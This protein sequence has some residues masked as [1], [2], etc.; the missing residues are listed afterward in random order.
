MQS[1]ITRVRKEGDRETQRGEHQE[2]GIM[3]LTN[4]GL[5]EATRNWERGVKRIL[6]WRLRK[7][8]TLLDTLVA[9]IW[10]PELCEK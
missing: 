4:Q 3:Q 7:Q 8:T 1:V 5:L 10:P 6:P 9:D 2:T